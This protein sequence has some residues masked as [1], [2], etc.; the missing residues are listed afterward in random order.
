M[1]K[2]SPRKKAEEVDVGGE[3]VGPAVGGGGAG[4]AVDSGFGPVPGTAVGDLR[5][6][7]RR[8]GAVEAFLKY[9]TCASVSP[10]PISPYGRTLDRSYN[11]SVSANIKEPQIGKPHQPCRK[12][13]NHYRL[14]YTFQAGLPDQ[15]TVQC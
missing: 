7:P 1:W 8:R 3:R 9:D 13:K 5:G 14:E 6:R 10:R 4:A 11:T 2:V 12:R 15:G